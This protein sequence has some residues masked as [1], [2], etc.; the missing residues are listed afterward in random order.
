[1]THAEVPARR[2]PMTAP[3]L[4]APAPNGSASPSPA[5]SSESAPPAAVD[6]ATA[7]AL[8]PASVA[9]SVRVPN[10]A[11][12]P[13]VAT[14]SATPA[15]AVVSRPRRALSF[16][17]RHLPLVLSVVVGIPLVLLAGPRLIG[18]PQ[19]TVD[20][21]V[22]TDFVQSIV[23]S[24]RVETP[25]RVEIG[26]QMTGAVRAVPVIDGQTVAAGAPLIVLESSELEAALAQ[27]T[28]QMEAASAQA[29]QLREV[30]GPAAAQTLRQVELARDAAVDPA[31]TQQD[32][33]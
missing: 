33:P 26:V 14:P 16:V 21:V 24:G 10:P 9:E 4:G 11:P 1:M 18:G 22:Q 15:P 12:P 19:V 27:A 31:R 8:A 5:P 7:P 25:H 3:T 28:R 17:G 6:R 23:A 30:Q 13:P 29:R 2:L 20:T 32:S